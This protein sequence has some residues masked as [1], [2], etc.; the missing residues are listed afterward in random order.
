MGRNEFWILDSGFWMRSIGMS[1]T[2]PKSKIANLKF[3]EEL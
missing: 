1:H 2:N 3:Q